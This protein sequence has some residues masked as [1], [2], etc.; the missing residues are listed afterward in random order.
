MQGRDQWLMYDDVGSSSYAGTY[1]LDPGHPDVVEYTVAAY[2][3]LAANYDLDGVHLDRVRYPYQDWGYN[4]TAVARF[5]A[6]TGRTDVPAPADPSGSSGGATNSRAWCARSTS[7]SPRSPQLRV[8]GALSAAGYAPSTAYPWETRTPYTHHL[9][10]WPGWLEEGILDLGLP[11]NYRRDHE[12]TWKVDFDNWIAW[13]KDHQYN[14]AVAVG[15]GLYLNSVPNS[16]SQWLRVRQASGLGNHA[17]GVIGYSYATPSND[18]TSKRSFVNAVV[19]NVFNQAADAPSLPW[20]D[21]PS[22]G[23][24]RGRLFYA[25]PCRLPLDGYAVTL[26]GP[27]TR[28]LLTDGWG[29]F[30][31]VDLPPGNY[32]LS[33]QVPGS[34]ETVRVPVVITA[35]AIA[36]QDLFLPLSPCEL[37]YLPV[38]LRSAAP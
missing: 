35:G 27:Q 1:W 28:A 11:M 21:A 13:E 16:V 31:A 25:P 26:T 6:Q 23:H 24:L 33:A 20:K 15:T 30:G 4:P 29:W 9:Q 32:L 3:E 12:P 10:D 7:P 36:E 14:R 22:L 18:G 8:S 34:G 19:A 38:A 2:A 5:Q 37:V 17:W